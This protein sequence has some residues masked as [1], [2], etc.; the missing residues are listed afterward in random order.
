MREKDIY[1]LMDFNLVF[2]KMREMLREDKPY[3]KKLDLVT[4]Y[5]DILKKKT[6]EKRL[7][8]AIFG[9]A[10]K[11]LHILEPSFSAII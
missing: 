9:Q 11:C 10:E 8:M 6:I 2:G 3:Q 5:W 4:I 7:K 1:I